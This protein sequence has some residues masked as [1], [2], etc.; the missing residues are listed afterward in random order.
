MSDQIITVDAVAWHDTVASHSDKA[1]DWLGAVDE[2]GRAD[3]I[4][5]VLRLRSDAGGV[6]LE[7]RVPRDGGHLTSI[8]DVF[9]GAS[10]GEREAAEALGLV[11]DGGDPRPLLLTTAFGAHPL[12][13]DFVLGARAAKP[14]PGA[15]EP[16]ES[17]GG[18]RRMVAP[19]VPDA[20]V[21]GDRQGEA[22][23]PEEIAA[24]VA[25]GRVRRRR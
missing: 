13:K 20:D 7:T 25:G 1:F 15:K 18:R 11:F 4:R 10:W 5:V 16:G 23:T 21:W 9:A 17:G 3:E 6:R 12:R 24:S 8:A 14:W 19:G 2:L 22:A